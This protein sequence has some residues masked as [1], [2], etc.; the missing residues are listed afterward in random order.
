MDNGSVRVKEEP[1][2]KPGLTLPTITHWYSTTGT[3]KVFVQL[4]SCSEHTILPKAKDEWDQTVTFTPNEARPKTFRPA[5]ITCQG[6][7]PRWTNWMTV[8]EHPSSN[9]GDCSPFSLRIGAA[10]KGG[11]FQFESLP[12]FKFNWDQLHTD[13]TTTTSESSSKQV[14]FR[15][16]VLDWFNTYI[17]NE[18]AKA[19]SSGTTASK[20]DYSID[21]HGS[22]FPF[23]D[24]KIMI[25]H[26]GS[27]NMNQ[28]YTVIM[29]KGVYPVPCISSP[30]FPF[31]LGGQHDL[32]STSV[33]SLAHLYQI[34]RT[35]DEFIERGQIYTKKLG[36]SML[37]KYGEGRKSIHK[38][39][40]L[41]LGYLCK[42]HHKLL[43]KSTTTKTYH[44]QLDGFVKL[45]ELSR[46]L[47]AD[48]APN[49][50][51]LLELKEFIVSYSIFQQEYYRR[52]ANLLEIF[53][54][55]VF[56]GME[57]WDQMSATDLVNAAIVRTSGA[58][59]CNYPNFGFSIYEKEKYSPL[60]ARDDDQFAK[61]EQLYNGMQPSGIPTFWNHM[62][63]PNLRYIMKTSLN[64]YDRIKEF[65]K[66]LHPHEDP[67]RTYL[68]VD[69]P[70]SLL[71]NVLF[72]L[73][74]IISREAQ[75]NSRD[76]STYNHFLYKFVSECS[77]QQ[78]QL[79]TDLLKQ[80]YEM[81]R[82]KK[83][84]PGIT[85]GKNVVNL[86]FPEILFKTTPR[87]QQI[88]V[89]DLVRIHGAIIQNK[90]IEKSFDQL[91]KQTSIELFN[92][93]N[94]DDQFRR[95]F[96]D[97]KD[98]LM[99]A[100]FGKFEGNREVTIQQSATLSKSSPIGRTPDLFLNP[101]CVILSCQLQYFNEFV[102][103]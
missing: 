49:S 95:S 103:Q 100:L 59:S 90:S 3:D 70:S 78:Y 94:L 93:Y 85:E 52:I 72:G 17:K 14:T 71:P 66:T 97:T 96:V 101:F 73:A 46:W 23:L 7:P 36:Q 28:N 88:L 99:A 9:P 91:L 16:L 92:S 57:Y 34:Y 13:L 4:V 63:T 53:C 56:F 80:T 47:T 12:K 61:G 62:I 79:T 69:S 43:F 22:Q 84:N 18:K 42:R 8:P 10:I 31:I 39:Y 76:P 32:F 24:P 77:T 25:E 40:R 11:C 48:L 75:V 44:M 86:Q 33:I 65:S 19:E 55:H 64:D 58:K 81:T 35:C 83:I 51:L 5:Q 2:A 21:P 15:Y 54:Y 74:Q 41:G 89:D 82:E 45:D 1:K 60:N 30:L 68:D 20:W 38:W 102:L 67:N 98:E 37:Y 87:E 27:K 29:T 50:Q 26:G 6:L